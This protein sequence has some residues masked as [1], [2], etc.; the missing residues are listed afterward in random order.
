MNPTYMESTLAGTWYDNHPGRLRSELKAALS[1]A[2]IPSNPNVF[3]VIMPHAGYAYSGRCAAHGAQAV[4]AVPALRRVIVLGLTHRIR[5]PNAVS[6]PSQATAYRSP[7]GDTPLDTD[8]IAGLL[9]DTLFTDVPATRR[10]ENSIEMQLPLLQVAL[11]GRDWSLVPIT[12]GQL[13]EEARARVAQTLAPLMDAGT[14]L[15]VSSDFTHY[16]PDFSYVPFQD[17]IEA[18]LRQVDGGAIQTILNGD[19]QG[20]A[21]YCNQ[22]GA[23]ICGQDPI[24]VML[25]MLPPGFT[26]QELAY[27]TSG[28]STG[29][30][31]NSVS[32]ATAAFYRPSRP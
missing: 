13:D 20:F 23:T 11:E 25:R 22:T 18:N 24:G 2:R 19:A 26:A 4:A 8:A 15:V 16:G 27:D 32:Y 7:L 31:T 10:G 30:F 3:A 12:L 5:L 1:A 28:R 14:V 17:D 21:A 9:E 6:L 29:D